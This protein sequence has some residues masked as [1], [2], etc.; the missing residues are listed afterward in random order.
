VLVRLAGASASTAL[1]IESRGAAARAGEISGGIL[2][3]T[4][5]QDGSWVTTAEVHPRRQFDRCAVATGESESVR[6][7]F[8]RECTIGSLAQM[9]VAETVA[10]ELLALVEASHSRFGEIGDAIREAGGTVASLVPGDSL[11]LAFTAPARD[12]EKRR[13][14]FLV[15]R[16]SME[17]AGAEGSSELA[18]VASDPR[19]A[20]VFALGLARP[21]PSLGAVAIDYTLAHKAHVDLRVYSVTGRL[22]RTLVNQELPAGPQAVAWDGRDDRGQWAGAGAYFYQMVAGDWR[23]GRKLVLLQR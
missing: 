6:L 4:P 1:V 8:L 18:R 22:V 3:Q 20:L 13:D 16:G 7:V 10:P 23:S 17:A 19:V 12:P 14:F 21:N 5:G 2:V 11:S 9:S 15:A